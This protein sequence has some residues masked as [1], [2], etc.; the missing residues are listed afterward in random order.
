[1]DEESFARPTMK[2]V[3][4]VVTSNEKLAYFNNEMTI[5]FILS[6]LHQCEVMC[7]ITKNYILASLF[8]DFNC[9]SLGS[10]A[11]LESSNCS[12]CHVNGNKQEFQLDKIPVHGCCPANRDGH[13]GYQHQTLSNI[14]PCL[15]TN[16]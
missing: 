15:S 1:M 13:C 11:C 8:D 5:S 4:R 12:G 7:T 2:Q 9:F 16:N 10:P 3:E 14:W 6:F